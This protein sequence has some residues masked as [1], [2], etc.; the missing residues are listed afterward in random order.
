MQ[1]KEVV[2]HDGH[3]GCKVVGDWVAELRKVV[4]DMRVVELRVGRCFRSLKLS[5]SIFVVHAFKN[6]IF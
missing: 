5:L 1:G 2:R 3:A 4:E 6:K